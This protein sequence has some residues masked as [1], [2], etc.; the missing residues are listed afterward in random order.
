MGWRC[1]CV[2]GSA[3]SNLQNRWVLRLIIHFSGNFSLIAMTNLRIHDSCACKRW[4][5]THLAGTISR[6]LDYIGRPFH[7]FS[8]WATHFSHCLWAQI[9]IIE[10][11]VD[12]IGIQ[13]T[14]STPSRYMVYVA[15]RTTTAQHWLPHGIRI[16]AQNSEMRKHRNYSGVYPVGVNRAFHGSTNATIYNVFVCLSQ[17]TTIWCCCHCRL[18]RE[19]CNAIVFGT[20]CDHEKNTCTYLCW[21]NMRRQCDPMMSQYLNFQMGAFTIFATH[22]STTHRH[23]WMW[24]WHVFR[25]MPPWSHRTLNSKRSE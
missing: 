14:H 15:R 11:E 9:I 4:F 25:S 10:F 13:N 21:S 2:A 20:D 5:A 8:A 22:Y 12:W 17:R 7:C 1:G 16:S 24:A 18:H 23:M 6:R 3:H 19:W